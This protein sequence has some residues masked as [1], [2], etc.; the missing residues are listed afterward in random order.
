MVHR[1]VASQAYS[2]RL[3]NPIKRL[4][5]KCNF[6]YEFQKGYRQMTSIIISERGM[7]VC[8]TSQTLYQIPNLN[9]EFSKLYTLIS[10]Q[11]FHVLFRVALSRRSCIRFIKTD[12]NRLEMQH[13]ISQLSPARLSETNQKATFNDS[14]VSVMQ[15]LRI[16]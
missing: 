10:R 3:L 11:I 1:L 16:I 6:P 14:T 8:H 7:I 15:F 2:R 5:D 9:G 12:G 13:R 4:R